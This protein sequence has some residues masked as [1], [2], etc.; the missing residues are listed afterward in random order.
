MFTSPTWNS[1]LSHLRK[2]EKGREV[3]GGRQTKP[4]NDFSLYSGSANLIK[5]SPRNSLRKKGSWRVRD[6]FWRWDSNWSTVCCGPSLYLCSEAV[7]AS[8]CSSE[9]HLPSECAP[10]CTNTHTHTGWSAIKHKIEGEPIF[11]RVGPLHPAEL[12]ERGDRAC[13]YSATLSGHKWEKNI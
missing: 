2:R 10:A 11:K 1:T 3:G 7:T 8:E 9:P 5:S 4:K 6:L 12:I 13:Q